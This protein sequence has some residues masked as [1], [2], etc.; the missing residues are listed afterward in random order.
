MVGRFVA[1]NLCTN[2]FNDF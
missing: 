1:C 2:V